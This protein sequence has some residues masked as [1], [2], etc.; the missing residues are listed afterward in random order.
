MRIGRTDCAYFFTERASCEYYRDYI[1]M[2]SAQL[3]EVQILETYDRFTGDMRWLDAIDERTA[4]ARDIAAGSRAL[5]GREKCPPI[6]SPR[7]CFKAGTDSRL[8]RK[9]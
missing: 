5:L 8:F 6:R 4:T 9:M 1:G 2:S 7:C 3:C